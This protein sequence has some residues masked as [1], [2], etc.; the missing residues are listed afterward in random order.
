MSWS[1]GDQ[2]TAD[3]LNSENN[4][5]NWSFSWVAPGNSNDDHT[6]GHQLF[7]YHDCGGINNPIIIEWHAQTIDEKYWGNWYSPWI[8]MWFE[9]RDN[10]GNIIGSRYTII[11]AHHGDENI[12]GN[13]KKND[14]ISH[15]GSAEGWYYLYYDCRDDKHGEANMY[16]T[17]YMYPNSNGV[18]RPLRYYNGPNSSDIS[19]NKELTSSNLNA[20]KIGTY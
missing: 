8:T 14:L 4:I 20:H 1:A 15:F 17:S 13:I 2:I 6:T 19:L 12:L 3:K 5:H 10:S 9:K 18:N 11:S 16:F 7:Y